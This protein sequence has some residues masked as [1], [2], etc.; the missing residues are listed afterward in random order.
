MIRDVS[1]WFRAYGFADARD[2]LLVG[3]Y[4]LDAG[5]VQM[6]AGLGVHRV[7]NLAQDDEYEPGQ[8]DDV[9]H[10]L[11]E[12]EIAETRVA[13]VDYGPLPAPELEAAVQQVVAWLE[14]GERTYVHCRAGWQRS[15]AVCA[16]VVAVYDEVDI[17]EALRRVQSRKP[18]AQPLPHQ[19]D[20]LRRW[21]QGR[22]GSNG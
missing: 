16:G 11:A 21:F 4:P 2:E 6:L 10:A 3:A 18:S 5:D 22:G 17:E 13:L 9:E 1:A 7:L 15:A 14:A 20:D 8:R 12:A 19:V